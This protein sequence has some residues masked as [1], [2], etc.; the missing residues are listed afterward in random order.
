[1]RIDIVVYDGFDELDA[2]GPLEVLRSAADLGADLSARLVSRTDQP[3]VV[4]S[5]GARV[6]IDGVFDPGVD[7]V[8]VA[9]GRWVARG[10]VGAWGEVQRGDWLPM[11][12][13]AADRGAL[14]ASVCTGAMLLAHAGIIGTRRATT[15]HAALAD[16]EATGA[17]VAVGRVVDDGDL[18]TCGGVTSGID[19][20]LWLVE[21]LASAEVAAAVAANLEYQP[22]RP[23]R[24]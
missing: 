1:M 15:H 16:L 22:V 5:H 18:V 3:V 20:A 9:G 14:M 6:G 4:G 11:L 2:L 7:G 10:D 12:V 13:A 21:R 23:A 17:T 19:L 8:V 24:R